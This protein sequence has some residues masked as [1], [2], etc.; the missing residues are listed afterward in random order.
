M[1]ESN[2]PT[3]ARP[4]PFPVYRKQPKS[5]EAPPFDFY[6]AVVD[7]ATGDPIYVRAHAYHISTKRLWAL[8]NEATGGPDLFAAV[9][10]DRE[11]ADRRRKAEAV[12]FKLSNLDPDQYPGGEITTP[13]EIKAFLADDANESVA[14]GLWPVYR[15][16]LFDRRRFRRPEDT[17]EGTRGDEGEAGEGPVSGGTHLRG[18][19]GGTQ[20]AANP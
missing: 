3:G 20:A 17:G 11:A 7:A 19:S 8:E 2:E 5:G 12:V 15:E 4:A 16:A 9:S 1:S 14:F 6:V 10:A 18:V 13:D